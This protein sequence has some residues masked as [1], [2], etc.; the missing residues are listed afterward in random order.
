MWPLYLFDT[1]DIPGAGGYHLDD[2]GTP[3]GK[4][5]VAD[6]MNYGEAWTVDATHE[7]L[8]M[9]GDPTTATIVDIMHTQL[10][11]LQEVCD[12]CE[13]DKYAYRKIGILVTDFCLPAY[14]HG[15]TS[16]PY[17]FT[18][19]LHKPVPALLP[20]GYLGIELPNGMW[21]Q[22]VKRDDNG[23]NTSRR[24]LSSHRVADRIGA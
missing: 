9:L 12:A 6:A 8:E 24:A 14:F 13:A 21:T 16:G 19:N 4:V 18:G 15:A 2:T 11:C 5:F 22:I 3:T 23:Q 20:G 17:D 7:L 10:R 1:T